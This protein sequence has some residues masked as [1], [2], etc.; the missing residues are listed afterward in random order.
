MYRS[1]VNALLG[2]IGLFYEVLSGGT[3]SKSWDLTRS[4]RT[5]SI[6]SGLMDDLRIHPSSE[7]FIKF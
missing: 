3:V 1:I 7:K 2:V 5:H 4:W 6:H